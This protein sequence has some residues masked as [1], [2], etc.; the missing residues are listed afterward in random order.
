MT[1]GAGVI[2]LTRAVTSVL[3]CPRRPVP[4]FGK[5]RR[6]LGPA[7]KSGLPVRL[8]FSLVAGINRP[9]PSW[10]METDFHDVLLRGAWISA[11]Q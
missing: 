2:G 9:T 5:A 11:R 4:G 1:G 6:L 3:R 8:G 10:C 7:G